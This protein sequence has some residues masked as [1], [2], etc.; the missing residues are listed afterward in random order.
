VNPTTWVIGSHGLLGRHV[1]R[2]VVQPLESSDIP[3]LDEARANVVLQQGIED[4][5]ARAAG[6]P[7]DLLWC[8]GAGVV[9]TPAELI[10]REQRVFERFLVDLARAAGRGSDGA[11]FLASSAGG[12]YAG[13]AGPPFTELAEPRPLTPYGRAKLAM[14]GALRDFSAA[15]GVRALA[16]RIA[17]LYGPGQNLD[18]PQGLVSQ[19]CLTHLTGQP[20][21]LYVSPDT[22]RD[23]LYVED[24]ARM[25]VAGLER[26]RGDADRFVVKVLASGRS[27]TA[28]GLIGES[29]RLFRRRPRIVFGAPPVVG[30]QVADL[31]LRSVRWVDLDRLARTPLPVGIARTADDV[32]RRLAIGRV[33]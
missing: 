7:W 10:D 14:E 1:T 23:Y 13:S 15:T 29:T 2:R 16:G 19:V 22:R 8:A 28:G 17:N 32:A 25:I 12:L 21:S 24:C 3:W 4:L 5:L 9:G 6:G 31:R 20:L 11:V 18:K 26:L 30:L 33:A 27:V